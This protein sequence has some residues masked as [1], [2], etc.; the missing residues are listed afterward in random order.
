ML[1]GERICP[2]CRSEAI[3]G[4]RMLPSF[5]RSMRLSWLR[6]IMT[7]PVE[8]P[9]CWRPLET[10]LTR[11]KSFRGRPPRAAGIFCR[12]K[13]RFSKADQTYIPPS[14]R[15]PDPQQNIFHALPEGGRTPFDG[16]EEN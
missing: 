12:Y 2:D 5:R 14:K 9:S 10:W 4:G 6:A 7:F 15:E 13:Q 8:R 3:V 11:S 16:K 1:A